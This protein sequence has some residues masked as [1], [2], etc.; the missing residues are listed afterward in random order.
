MECKLIFLMFCVSENR[1]VLSSD[2]C[3]SLTEFLLNDSLQK[4]KR[5]VVFFYQK[6]PRARFLRPQL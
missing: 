2:F 6:S 5:K 1:L 3:R 4:W